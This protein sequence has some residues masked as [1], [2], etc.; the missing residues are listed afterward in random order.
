[1]ETSV[2]CA[3]ALNVNQASIVPIAGINEVESTVPSFI[4]K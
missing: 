3:W 2:S 1:M 4:V